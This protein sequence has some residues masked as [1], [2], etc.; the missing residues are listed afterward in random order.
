M[1][2][3]PSELIEGAIADLGSAALW[4]AFAVQL[5]QRLRY[6]AAGT[7]AL[8]EWLNRVPATKDVS[9][10]EIVQGQHAD[11]AAANLTVRNLITSMRAI[12]A[13]D[14]RSFFE[15]V[16][17]VDATLRQHPGFV[18][19][20]FATR[21]RYRHAIEDLA[22]GSACSEIDV[23]AAAIAKTEPFRTGARTSNGKSS[24]VGETER[25]VES[26]PRLRDPGF[27][28][29]A[30][31]REVLERELGYR[32]GLRER[33]RRAFLTRATPAY[34]GAILLLTIAVA[35][36][37]LSASSE[38]AVDLIGLLMLGLLS[39]LPASDMAI[40]LCNRAVTNAF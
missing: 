3:K 29:I 2:T 6:Q 30:A 34:L 14:W 28:L 9:V 35:A 26:D 22:K 40:A 4:P 7:T 16:S 11:Q 23:A 33:F 38:L 19:M 24:G 27:Y 36:V 32:I 17:L 31:G 13:F 25:G 21:D 20:D 39:L 10:D 15:E 12:A 8:L 1:E 18:A 37:P 5:V